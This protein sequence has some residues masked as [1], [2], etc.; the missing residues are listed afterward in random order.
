MKCK[1]CGGDH[2]KPMGTV[3]DDTKTGENATILLNDNG[4]LVLRC[5]KNKLMKRR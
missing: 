3:S 5:P 1:Y 2:S 4:L